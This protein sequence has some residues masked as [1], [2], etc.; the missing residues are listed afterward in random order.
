MARGN[1]E[2]SL[3]VGFSRV[4]A[5]NI[6]AEIIAPALSRELGQ[7][8][9]IVSLPGGNGAR[10]TEQTAQAAPDGLT[11]CITVPTH[12]LNS[13]FGDR[14]RHDVTRDFAPVAVFGRNPLVLA[15]ST[16]RSGGTSRP[17]RLTAGTAP[18]CVFVPPAFP[19]GF[20]RERS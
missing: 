10:A 3:L 16:M 11:L 19:R 6:V 1:D 20:R 2:V 4:S 15:V 8:V 18:L 14:E 5:S 9:R 12:V 7:P 17:H 13:L